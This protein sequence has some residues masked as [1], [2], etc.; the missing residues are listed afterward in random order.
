MLTP[1]DLL[2]HLPANP[3]ILEAGAHHGEDT[4]ALAVNASWVYA[5][6]PVPELHEVTERVT[7]PCRNVTLERLALG[8][9]EAMGWMHISNGVNDA[10]SSLLAPREHDTYYPHI[11]F[12]PQPIPVVV[13]TIEAWTRAHH[14]D[15]IDGMWLDL[16]GMEL[17][18]L[19]AAGSILQTTT[20]IMLEISMVELYDGCPL[21]PTVRSW[22]AEQGFTVQIEDLYSKHAGDALVVREPRA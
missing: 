5:F 22:L 10:S 20:A 9:A 14:V 13:T 21:W 7:A 1:R 6:E 8:G 4:V 15:R 3:V 19:Q 17:A 16:Q 2:D 18:A 11:S 12:K